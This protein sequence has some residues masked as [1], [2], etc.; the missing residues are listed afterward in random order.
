VVRTRVGY[1]GGSTPNP[2]YR[3]IGDHSETLQLDYDPTQ[4][5]YRELL[6]VFWSAHNP[7]APSISRQYASIIFYHDEVQKEIA[8]Q[9]VADMTAQAG[10]LWSELLP[11]GEFYWAEDYHQKYQLRGQRDLAAELAS[12]Y[13]DVRDLVNSTAATRINGYAGRNGSLEQLESEID[14]LGLSEESQQRL[15]ET[16]SAHSRFG[17]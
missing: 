6:Q 8:E 11:A 7:R 10:K 9:S 1:A 13:P 2:T 5:T 3:S 12:I 17:P 16:V 15:R 4:I 14:S